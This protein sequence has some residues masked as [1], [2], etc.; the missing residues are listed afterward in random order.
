MGRDCSKEC[1]TSLPFAGDIVSVLGLW[2]IGALKGT[3]NYR[4]AAIL[5]CLRT[6]AVLT[7]EKI[8]SFYHPS[9][10]C[11]TY[12][13]NVPGSELVIVKCVC[14]PGNEAKCHP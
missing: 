13:R 9:T 8:P 4:F 11:M 1:C 12:V 14:G 6:A 3:Y 7:H 10:L 5:D 2:Y